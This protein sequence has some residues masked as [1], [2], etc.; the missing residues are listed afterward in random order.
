METAFLIVGLGNPTGQYEHTRHNAGFDC[1]DLLASETS[2]RINR[3]SCRA[4]IGKGRIGAH[5]V[6]LAKPQTYMN[7]S[8]QAVSALMRYYKIDPAHLIV[9]YDD[10]DLDT[11]R[12]R[13]RRNGSAGGHNGMKDI[14]AMLGTQEFCRIRIGIGRRPEYMEMVDYV[15]GRPAAGDRERMEE[16]FAQAASAARDIVENGPDHAMNAYNH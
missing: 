2:I 3:S 14:I 9:I 4:H 12:I 5:K 8:G 15:L 10:T 7:L 6:I 11:G 13:I 16:A 1:L